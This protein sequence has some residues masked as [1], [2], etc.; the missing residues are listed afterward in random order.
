MTLVVG[1]A[2]Q[3]GGVLASDSQE[4]VEAGAIRRLD[5]RKLWPLVNGP[6]VKAAMGASGHHGMMVHAYERVA[7]KVGSLNRLTRQALI[8]VAEE[9]LWDLSKRY[10]HERGKSVEEVPPEEATP[11][12]LLIAGMDL[13][14]REP[15]VVYLPGSG[16]DTGIA[17]S[18]HD[19]E[20]VGATTYA[21]YILGTLYRKG[22]ERGQALE[23]AIYTIAETERI[24]PTVGGSIQAI[25]VDEKEVEEL[26]PVEIQGLLE[27]VGKRRHALV[28]GWWQG[29]LP[30]H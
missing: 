4:D 7:A 5:V 11:L 24:C 29:G 12:H 3:D 1:L 17:E 26:S 19:Y 13:E 27:N 14:R 20:A 22:L 21:Y 28:E 30:V 8:S 25:V 15:F 10:R 2:F 16:P 6:K 23:L 9:A 18:P